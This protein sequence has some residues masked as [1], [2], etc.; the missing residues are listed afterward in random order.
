MVFFDTKRSGRKSYFS[1]E[2]MIEILKVE[3]AGIFVDVICGKHRINDATFHMWQSWFNR[4][5]MFGTRWRLKC[6]MTKTSA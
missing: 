1:G 4:M 2:Q 6:S 3:Q 5:E